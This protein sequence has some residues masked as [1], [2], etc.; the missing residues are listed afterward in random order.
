M[1]TCISN[2]S[3]DLMNGPFIEVN[4]Q[5]QTSMASVYAVGDLIGGWQLAHVASAEGLVAAAN[6][7]GA[8]EEMDY[9]VVPR[10]IY[11]LP[12]IASVGMSEED[13]RHKGY[14]VKVS[15]NYYRG[16]GKAIAMDETEGFVKIIVRDL[17]IRIVMLISDRS[18]D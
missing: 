1:F 18:K 11:T 9:H 2:I 3:Y 10:C 8:K 17:S 7:T 16:N 5:M 4:P 13:A 15:K 14:D 12:E 6:A